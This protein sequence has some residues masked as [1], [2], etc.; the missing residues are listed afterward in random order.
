MA[1]FN[2]VYR[3]QHWCSAIIKA[4]QE[5]FRYLR[6]PSKL[7]VHR[8][9]IFTISHC[10][11][12]LVSSSCW[13]HYCLLAGKLHRPSDKVTLHLIGGVLLHPPPP[14]WCCYWLSG[15][16]QGNLHRTLKAAW[17]L[18]KH[19]IWKTHAKQKWTLVC[20]KDWRMK[21]FTWGLQQHRHWTSVKRNIFQ[22]LCFNWPINTCIFFQCFIL[23]LLFKKKPKKHF[24]SKKVWGLAIHV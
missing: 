15:S 9:P 3:L 12:G 6:P 2:R 5:I 16:S 22:S 23:L 11:M 20:V 19:W 13:M 17:N 7:W 4:K 14:D 18:E 24:S 10:F 1:F 21:L 8:G